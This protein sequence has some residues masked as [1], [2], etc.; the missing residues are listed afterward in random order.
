MFK[1]DSLSIE[2]FRNNLE[3]KVIKF[4]TKGIIKI[5]RLKTKYLSFTGVSVIMWKIVRAIIMIGLCH[6][7]LYPFIVK[8]IDSFKSLEDFLDPTVRYIP[9]YFNFENIKKVIVRTDYFNTMLN[10]TCLAGISAIL[11]MIISSLIGYGFARFKFKGNSFLFFCVILTLIVPPQ[12][13]MI[14]LYIRFRFF[15]GKINLI[16]TPWP[17]IITSGLG[18]GIKS[19]LYIFMFR[20]F[21]KNIPKELEEAAYIDGCNIFQTFYKI[22]IP[23]SGVFLVTVFLLSFSWQWTD[24][25]YSSIFMSKLQIFSNVVER[26]SQGESGI[27]VIILNNASALMAVLP[28]A[29]VYIIGQK[30][31]VESIQRSGIVG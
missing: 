5:E 20:Q 6:L 22:V 12:T 9:K 15:L 13:I 18:I 19:G 26:A 16:S 30:F 28:L 23:S 8:I 31:F 10:T 2:Y 27:L 24:T 1:V 14:P 4:V 25:V 3:N 29:L 7:I 11:N 17:V 21:F